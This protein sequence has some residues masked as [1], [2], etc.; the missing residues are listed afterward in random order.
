MLQFYPH[1]RP[2]VIL[3]SPLKADE[4]RI[5]RTSAE[6][7]SRTTLLNLEKP[8]QTRMSA[9]P[10]GKKKEKWVRPACRSTH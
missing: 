10:K 6:V 7:R 5:P 8:P 1:S 2:L 4:R 3:R 9:P